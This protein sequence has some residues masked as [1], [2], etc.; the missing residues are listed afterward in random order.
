MLSTPLI[1]CSIGVATD[2]STVCASAPTYV[3]FT[4]T[5]GG[6]IF[7]NCAV[8]KLSIAT[9]PTITMMIEITMATMGRFMK[10]LDTR[11]HIEANVLSL[12][13]SLFSTPTDAAE[14]ELP[15]FHALFGNLPLRYVRRALGLHQQSTWRRSWTRL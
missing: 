2:C 4:W 1:C 9:K 13:N 3:A 15:C 6:V 14:V 7:G 10:N 12:L 11:I 5:S 8:G